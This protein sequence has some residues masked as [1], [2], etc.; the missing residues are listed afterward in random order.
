MTLSQSLLVIKKYQTKRLSAD[1]RGSF[2]L[3]KVHFYVKL[4][5]LKL[6]MWAFILKDYIRF[7]EM[8]L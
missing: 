8:K 1:K 4:I 3:I 7:D 2:A 5:L 6:N